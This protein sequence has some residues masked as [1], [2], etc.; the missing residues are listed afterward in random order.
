MLDLH[1]I[2]TTPGAGA[3]LGSPG[4][5]AVNDGA[6]VAGVP[7]G[8][9]KALLRMWGFHAPTADSINAIKMYSQDMVDPV[10]GVTVNLGATSVMTQFYDYTMLAYKK[11]ARYITAGTNVGVVAGTAFTVDEYPDGGPVVQV[12]DYVGNEVMTGST[13]FGGALTTNQ[14]G[15]VAYAPTNA[16]PNGKYAI[17]GAYV[18]GITNN[19]LIRFNHPDF[20]GYKPGF[21]VINHQVALATAAQLAMKDQLQLTAQ[22]EQ[23]IYLGK[24][25]GRPQCPV[26]TASNAGTG[27]T[28]EMCDVQADTPSVNLVLAKVG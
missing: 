24:V 22:G 23:F 18:N 13:T 11:G 9:E 20:K 19:A 26:F 21:P 27:L 5:V 14:W 12:P 10:N 4:A 17:L 15:S 25:L 8:G 16:L 7:I 1:A 28:F 3:V 2:T 6:Q